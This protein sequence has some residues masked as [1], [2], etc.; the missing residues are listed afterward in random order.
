MSKKKIPAIRFQGFTDEWEKRKLLNLMETRRGLTYSPNNI[1]DSGVRV[2]RSSNIDEDRFLINSDDVFVDD[3]AVNI[4][5]VHNG[6]ILITSANGSSRL[7]GKHA[8]ISGI[9]ERTAVHGGFMLLGKTRNPYFVNAL[10]SSSWYLDFINVYVAGGNGAIGNLNKN[11][12]DSQTVMVPSEHEQDMIGDFFRT[13]DHL[14]TIHQRKLTKLQLLK[15]SM[16]TKMFPK[17]GARV[18]EIRFQGFHGDWEQRRLGE[19]CREFKSGSFISA[20]NIESSGEYPVWG[21][22]G[23]R[24][25]TSIYNHDGEFALIGRQGALCGNISYSIGKA[26]FTEHAIAVQANEIADTKFM[27]YLLDMMNL[28]QYSDQSAQPG[29][30]VGKLIKLVNLFPSV[31]EQ[32]RISTYFTNLDRLITLQQRNLSKL[33]QIKQAMLSKLFV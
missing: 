5:K 2:L 21:G 28:G 7:V 23:L 22:N 4:P 11:D 18:P 1:R 15:K 12:L 16:L 30:A 9:P 14:I 3:L 17:D 10:M 13:I 33:Q 31:E 27:H 19:C 25:F 32:K 20:N 26:Y 29:L 8:I 24:G 6:D